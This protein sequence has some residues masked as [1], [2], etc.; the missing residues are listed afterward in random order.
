MVAARCAAGLNE[1]ENEEPM[2]LVVTDQ[3]VSFVDGERVAGRYVLDDPFKPFI[4]PLKTPAGH[5]VSLAMPH[6][7]PHHKGLMYA[8]R[9]PQVNFWEERSTLPG[10]VVGRQIHQRFDELTEVG[11]QVGFVE[12][13]R[14]ETEA[15][16]ALFQERRSIS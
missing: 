4:H 9:T 10:E 7:H 2:Q 16:E 6:D 11:E 1:P 8:L 5:T 12:I 15:G 3:A 13:L 14:W